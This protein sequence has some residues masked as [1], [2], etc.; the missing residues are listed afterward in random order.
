MGNYYALELFSG[1]KR[2]IFFSEKGLPPS[3]FLTVFRPC[4]RAY[5][6][7]PSG[8]EDSDDR[9]IPSHAYVV[10]VAKLT[11]RLEVMGFTLQRLEENVKR[12]LKADR[13]ELDHRIEY[14]E[15]EGTSMPSYYR[16]LKRQRRTLEQFTLRRW[17]NSM[18]DFRTRESL[19]PFLVPKSSRKEF[20][21]L[22]RHML[23]ADEEYDWYYFGLPVSDLRYL[24]RAVLL[25]ADADEN[26]FL[27]LTEVEGDYF[28]E[29]D[30]PVQ[31]ALAET[32]RVGKVCEKILVLTEGRTDTRILSK[33]LTILYPHL[34]DLYSFLDH[35]AFHFGGGTG[36][37]ASLVKG[38]AGVGIG[39]RVI[40]VFDNDTAGAIQADDVRK[41]RLPEN[42]RILTLPPLKFARRYPTIGPNGA[43]RTDINGCACSIELYLG[44]AALTDE[45]GSLIPVQWRGYEAKL[46]RYQGELVDKKGVEHRY[47]DAL[48]APESLDEANL[49]SMRAVLQMIFTAFA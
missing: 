13:T 49:A 10:S 25:C 37:L 40:A 3:E 45:D 47:L 12:C 36:N 20:T 39:N 2:Q 41:L 48:D 15:H 28:A 16:K 29:G 8:V 26:V 38:L 30:E 44:A 5:P 35:E 23:N 18:R 27:D 34:A 31:E 17:V 14:Y 24:L 4:D 42:F 1:D 19:S 7:F 21:S 46:K 43:L 33:S 6:S 22:Q 11:E 9:Y 32:I